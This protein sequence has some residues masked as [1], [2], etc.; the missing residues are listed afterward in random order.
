MMLRLLS[1]PHLII[2]DASLSPSSLCL[3]TY[4]HRESL[5]QH[6]VWHPLVKFQLFLRNGLHVPFYKY[7][8][9]ILQYIFMMYIWYYMIL[10]WYWALIVAKCNFDGCKLCTRLAPRCILLTT[11]SLAERN[12]KDNFGGSIPTPGSNGHYKVRQ[13]NKLQD[14]EGSKIKSTD[15]ANAESFGVPSLF[16]TQRLWLL[17]LLLLLSLLVYLVQRKHKP[18][19]RYF[20]YHGPWL[21]D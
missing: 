11:A 21:H 16:L 6:L 10:R 18:I 9:Y 5:A 3:K 15:S 7:R 8:E 17:L 12:D 1:S 2:C 13:G 4:T 20:K 14:P 19:S